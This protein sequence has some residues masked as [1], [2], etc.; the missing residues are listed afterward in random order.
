MSA[1]LRIFE[2]REQSIVAGSPAV[3]ELQ[4]EIIDELDAMGTPPAAICFVMTVLT[5]H[6]GLTWAAIAQR[7]RRAKE[8]RGRIARQQTEKPELLRR[9]LPAFH[10]TCAYCDRPGTFEA[11][12]DGKPWNLDRI[13]PGAHGGEYEARN[14]ALA[15][16]ACNQQKGAYVLGTLPASLAEREA[17]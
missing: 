5:P 15:C 1:S 8:R 11:D 6:G 7:I 4:R 10:A 2:P 16:L 17:A 12:P 9:C 13:F 3:R 14:V